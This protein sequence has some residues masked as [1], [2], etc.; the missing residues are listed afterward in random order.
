MYGRE[1]SGWQ[2]IR[3]RVWEGRRGEDRKGSG[4]EEMQGKGRKWE[5]IVGWG[6]RV[7]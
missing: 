2:G 1:R 5:S 7:E 6:G 4:A 3:G